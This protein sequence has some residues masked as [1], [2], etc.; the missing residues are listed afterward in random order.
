MNLFATTTLATLLAFF[1]WGMPVEQPLIVGAPI[2]Q[3]TRTL[4]PFTDSLYDIGTSTA[5]YREAHI[6]SLCVGGAACVTSLASAGVEDIFSLTNA[7]TIESTTTN[8]GIGLNLD[9]FNAT[10]TAATSTFSG[11]VDIGTTSPYTSA[12]VNIEIQ[13]PGNHGLI[14][15]GAA[16]QS[17][18]LFMLRNNA[19]TILFDVENSGEVEVFHSAAENGDHTLHLET[20]VGGFGD[21]VGIFSDYDAGTL[22][23]GEDASNIL[24]TLDRRN[25][26][27][28]DIHGILVITTIG[29]AEATALEVGAGVNVIRQSSGTFGDM[30]SC[31]STAGGDILSSC[32]SAASDVTL[33]ASNTDEFVVGDA[34]QFTSID[35]DLATDSSKNINATFEF[36]TGNDTWTTFSPT[37]GTNGFQDS[38]QITWELD[39]IPTWAT[40][41]STR[42]FIRV[43]RTRVGNI[44]TPPV[45]NLIQISATSEF[46]WDLNGDILVRNAT[47]TSATTTNYAISGLTSALLLTDANGS[48]GEYTGVTCTN[49]FLRILS[50]LGAGTCATVSLTADVTGTLPTGNGGTGATSLDDIVGTANQI[51]VANGANTIIGGDST[52]S[53]PTIII[54][55]SYIGTASSTILSLSSTNATS[56][57]STSTNFN[58]AG[59]TASRVTALDAVKNFVTTFAS[60][61]LLDSLS[62]ETGTGVSVFG[63][64]PTFTTSLIVTDG[65][66]LDA[67][68]MD[69][70]TGNDYEINGTAVLNATTLG[71]AVVNSS[72]TGVGTL[73]GLTA[74]GAID[75]GGAVLEIPNATGPTVDAVGE[76]AV[77]TTSGQLIWHDG[78]LKHVITATTTA[79]FNIASTT[80][81]TAGNTFSAAT[82]T[83][84]IGGF[85]ELMTITGVNCYATTTGTALG[86]VGDFQNWSDFDC[87]ATANGAFTAITSNNTFTKFEPMA[88]QASSTIGTVN[89]LFITLIMNKTAD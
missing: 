78:R 45:E 21:V 13:T 75:F 38:S 50:A 66:T 2:T 84:Q 54:N 3:S 83:F 7:T 62:D 79:S 34:A 26:T 15:Q 18:H 28:G 58:L 89:R 42:Y 52:L 48:L 19:G 31:T 77:D 64:A 80:L 20:E 81:D 61:A 41:T 8:A 25:T 11:S 43:T 14:I 65:G 82:S 12:E 72:L 68:G 35:I 33:F 23:A 29:T 63:T 73:A 36:S 9:F 1:G 51:T 60:A 27:G 69:I 30:D 74:T 67:D 24:L 46:M 55:P 86:R 44:A 53:H 59:G 87:D 40:G 85:P 22:A 49:Q 4:I 88:I 56:T 70:V 71:G 76:F 17:E 32:T 6:D 10:G 39:D 16:S 47:T 5:A 37:D 57:H